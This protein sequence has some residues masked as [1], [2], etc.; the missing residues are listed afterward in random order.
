MECTN[1]GVF[2]WGIFNFFRYVLM[3]LIKNMKRVFVLLFGLVLGFL[4]PESASGQQ[5]T[6][7]ANV[8]ALILQPVNILKVRDMNFGY[9]SPGSTAGTV[10]LT[11][12]EA[13]HRSSSGGVTLQMG[14][15]AVN[16]AKFIVSGADGYPFS[17]IL[18]VTPVILSNGLNTMTIDHFTSTPSGSGLF[19]SGSQPICIGATLNVNAYQAAGV[20]MTTENFEVT[21]NYN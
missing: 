10:V 17:I 2:I 6:A 5:S 8:M 19:T 3:C 15:S 11:S 21:I 18:P 13:A 4:I 20:Y 1:S 16:S 12:A 14:N 9:L 7:T